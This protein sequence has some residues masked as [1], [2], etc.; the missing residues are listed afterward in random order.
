MICK[1]C[2]SNA[3]AGPPLLRFA[4]PGLFFSC[5]R[6]IPHPAVCRATII[7][8]PGNC[9]GSDT[10]ALESRPDFRLIGALFLHAQIAP[11]ASGI[12]THKTGAGLAVMSETPG[13]GRI[14]ASRFAIAGTLD[15]VILGFHTPLMVASFGSV[16]RVLQ[17]VDPKKPRQHELARLLEFNSRRTQE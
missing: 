13:S 6:D 16:H 8:S 7:K 15:A 12:T 1:H 4:T 17:W 3:A 10:T 14:N 5:I 9:R 2:V 11:I